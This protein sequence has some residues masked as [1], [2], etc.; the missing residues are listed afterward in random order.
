VPEGQAEE[1]AAL[2]RQIMENVADI[3]VPLDAEAGT[4]KS[5]GAAH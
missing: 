1:T 2:V 4:G 3:G 5:W